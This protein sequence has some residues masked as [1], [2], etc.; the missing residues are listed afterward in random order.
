MG[1]TKLLALVRPE[2]SSFLAAVWQPKSDQQAAQQGA[3]PDRLQLRSFLAPLPAAGEL[4]RCVAS[5]LISP[6]LLLDKRISL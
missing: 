2:S 5:R 4:S 6:Y 1:A 3:A